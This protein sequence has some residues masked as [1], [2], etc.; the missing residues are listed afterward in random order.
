[1]LK[2]ESGPVEEWKNWSGYHKDA[3][4]S[5]G[6]RQETSASDEAIRAAKKGMPS[7]KSNDNATTTDD[8]SAGEAEKKRK[9]LPQEVLDTIR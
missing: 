2:W 5:N 8:T 3:E 6:F 9:E 4:N 7:S 1:M